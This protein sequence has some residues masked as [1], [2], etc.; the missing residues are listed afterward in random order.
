MF[1]EKCGRWIAFPLI[2]MYLLS[3]STGSP[4]VLSLMYKGVNH[5]LP[6]F[7]TIGLAH[8]GRAYTCITFVGCG[9]ALLYHQIQFG[10]AA[11]I[12]FYRT[13]LIGFIGFFLVNSILT[14]I[15]TREPVVIYN[16]EEYLGIRLITIPLDDVAY[17]FLLLLMS[18]TLYDFKTF[19]SFQYKNSNKWVNI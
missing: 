17:N 16:P 8:W 5:W 9:I 19:Y 3:L 4:V 7:L 15:A 14:G 12:R 1:L 2:T 18:V 13:F 6:S 11:R 10:S